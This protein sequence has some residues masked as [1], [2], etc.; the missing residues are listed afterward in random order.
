M[1]NAK[2]NMILVQKLMN[3]LTQ[4]KRGMEKNRDSRSE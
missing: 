4:E 3:G 2:E 1:E